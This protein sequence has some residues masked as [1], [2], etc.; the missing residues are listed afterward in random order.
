MN[1]TP[2]PETSEAWDAVSR[3]PDGMYDSSIPMSQF[4]YAM[5][6]HSRKLERERDEA[7]AQQDRLAD[8]LGTIAYQKLSEELSDHNYEHANW[9]GSWDYVINIARK[10]IQPLNQLTK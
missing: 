6:D 10:S 1:D 3:T 8:A 4:A 2:T 5:V 9:E 7:R